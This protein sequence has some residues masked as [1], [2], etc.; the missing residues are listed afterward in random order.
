M[1]PD[2]CPLSPHRLPAVSSPSTSLQGSLSTWWVL[3]ELV[4][5]YLITS[6]CEGL[7]ASR[8]GVI[9]DCVRNVPGG[10]NAGAIGAALEEH[11]GCALHLVAEGPSR[12]ASLSVLSALITLEIPDLPP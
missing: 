10:S 5:F 4:S 7:Q 9:W 2:L 8:G 11:P 12:V 6:V 3:F 1:K